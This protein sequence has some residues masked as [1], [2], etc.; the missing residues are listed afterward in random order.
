MTQPEYNFRWFRDGDDS[1]IPADLLADALR[2]AQR[3]FH[4]AGM[5]VEQ[6]D[7][8]GERLRARVPAEV[9]RKYVLRCKPAIRGSYDVPTVLGF[10]GLVDDPFLAEA[11]TL[12]SAAVDAGSRDGAL[13]GLNDLPAGAIGRAF[14]LAVA[15]I[16]PPRPAIAAIFPT[17]DT[18]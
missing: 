16:A 18:P 5:I 17:G 10:D 11:S 2:A 8:L 13:D 9:A 4:L 1:E 7:R 15:G 12:F 14:L 3:A 6:P